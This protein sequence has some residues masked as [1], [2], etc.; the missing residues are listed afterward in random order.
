MTDLPTFEQIWAQSITPLV[1]LRLQYDDGRSM[2]VVR[3]DSSGITRQ[4]SNGLMSRIPVEPFEWAV[5]QLRRRGR[6]TRAEINEEFP[7]RYS[8]AVTAILA[9]VPELELERRPL[10]LGVRHKPEISRG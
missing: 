8:S 4:S 10:T 2:L 5:D 9:Q 7:R 6:V 1:G 3:V